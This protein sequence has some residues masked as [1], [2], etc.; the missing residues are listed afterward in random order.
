MFALSM[1]EHQLYWFA[2]AMR[3]D[4]KT[5]ATITNNYSIYGIP[6]FQSC[7]TIQTG[8]LFVVSL[9][10]FESELHN[11]V[12]LSPI[13]MKLYVLYMAFFFTCLFDLIENYSKCWKRIALLQA[14]YWVFRFNFISNNKTVSFVKKWF[15]REIWYI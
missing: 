4:A 7:N 6:A 14:K 12:F 1:F 8:L 13:H 11:L 3:N 15:H 10:C 2:I 5:I 9:E